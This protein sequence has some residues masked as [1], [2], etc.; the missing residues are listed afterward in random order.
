MTASYVRAP[1]AVVKPAQPSKETQAILRSSLAFSEHALRVIRD[2]VVE[3]EQSLICLDERIAEL[4]SARATTIEFLA[5][6]R[7]Q[8]RSQYDALL[9]TRHAL[10]GSIPRLPDE[11]LARIFA[12]TDAPTLCASICREWRHVALEMPLL[13][14][15]ISVSFGEFDGARSAMVGMRAHVLSRIR[16]SQTVPLDV[17]LSFHLLKPST[18]PERIVEL[19]VSQ[20]TR[21]RS[22]DITFSCLD[23]WDIT[24]CIARLR[25]PAPHL[26]ALSVTIEDEAYSVTSMLSSGPWLDYTYR[27]ARCKLSR[28]PI[29]LISD[30]ELPALV[31]LNFHGRI[32]PSQVWDVANSASSLAELSVSWLPHTEEQVT[33]SSPPCAVSFP[34]VKRLVLFEQAY[35]LLQSE[36]TVTLPTVDELYVDTGMPSAPAFIAG[37]AQTL[38][39]LVIGNARIYPEDVATLLADSSSA[40]EEVMW[41][42]LR[43]LLLECTDFDTRNGPL[44]FLNVVRARNPFSPRGSSALWRRLDLAVNLTPDC[45]VPAWQFREI[46]LLTNTRFADVA[47]FEDLADDDAL[48]MPQRPDTSTPTPKP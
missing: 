13:W 47:G 4:Q 32:I 38:R 28:A 18:E 9:T 22:F 27:L 37:I 43:V 45:E 33:S 23:E 30:G 7:Q 34:A 12:S 44:A 46:A 31:D 42:Q 17:S 10:L 35:S 14:N 25:G 11:L 8:E 21:W 39:K 40:A 20:M 5:D 1:S 2:R 36:T 19:L 24:S 6:A 26:E 41:P 48:D 3:L 29:Q 16:R 15:N